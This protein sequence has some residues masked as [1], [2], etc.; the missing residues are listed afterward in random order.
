MNTKFVSASWSFLGV[1]RTRSSLNT[2]A[3]P[4]RSTYAG[5]HPPPGFC[6]CALMG[7]GGKHRASPPPL[8]RDPGR[9]WRRP[10][11]AFV[12][13]AKKCGFA[14]GGGLSAGRRGSAGP[15]RGPDLAAAGRPDDDD[16]GRDGRSW[17]A[18]APPRSEG[19]ASA[20][21]RG[22]DGH[23]PARSQ[24][25]RWRARVVAGRFGAANAG[26]GGQT[27]LTRAAHG[28]RVGCSNRS[29]C[30]RRPRE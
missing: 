18:T 14:R 2:Q 3:G 11:P 30:V 16:V 23:A 25:T 7:R 27:T 12:S 17:C 15:R 24:W 5:E 21:F 9:G 28:I 10:S 26:E 29:I 4:R 19:R 13:R 1:E 22:A 6:V 8:L 20:K